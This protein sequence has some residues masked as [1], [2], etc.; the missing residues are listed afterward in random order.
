MEFDRFTHE[1]ER[2]GEGCERI[3]GVDEAGRG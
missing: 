2:L 3:A 1:R